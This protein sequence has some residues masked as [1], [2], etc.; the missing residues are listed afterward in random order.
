MQARMA[1]DSITRM[2]EDMLAAGTIRYGQMHL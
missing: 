1:A 2:A